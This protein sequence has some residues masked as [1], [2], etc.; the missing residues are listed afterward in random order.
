MANF[1]SITHGLNEA[2]AYLNS[3]YSWIKGHT[4]KI[5]IVSP[6]SSYGVFIYKWDTQNSRWITEFNGNC[7]DDGTNH[8]YDDKLDIDLSL[9]YD[10]ET[11]TYS[12]TDYENS[13]GLPS[14]DSRTDGEK[15]WDDVKT[16][17]QGDDDDVKSLLAVLGAVGLLGFSGAVSGTAILGAA[18]LGLTIGSVYTYFK[19]NESVLDYHN[20][21]GN[22]F[23]FDMS[24]LDLDAGNFFD[25]VKAMTGFVPYDPLLKSAHILGNLADTLISKYSVS[26]DDQDN[27]KQDLNQVMAP[28]VDGA[29]EFMP[30]NQG[31]KGSY[32]NLDT[33]KT[34]LQNNL[35]SLSPAYTGSVGALTPEIDALPALPDFINDYFGIV[36]PSAIPGDLLQ[37]PSYPDGKVY[38]GELGGVAYNPTTGE[39]TVIKKG[40]VKNLEINIDVSGIISALNPLSYLIHLLAMKDTM[41]FNK[42]T[43]VE[44]RDILNAK[45]MSPDMTEVNRLVIIKLLADYGYSVDG[46]GALVKTGDGVRDVEKSVA[47]LKDAEY[48]HQ[49]DGKEKIQRDG[50]AWSNV[51][52]LADAG[53]LP[54]TIGNDV[55]VMKGLIPSLLGVGSLEL[56]RELF[57]YKANTNAA[58]KAKGKARE[59]E[60]ED[61]EESFVDDFMSMIFRFKDIDTSALP[62]ELKEHLGSIVSNFGFEQVGDQSGTE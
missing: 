61:K 27:F 29:L 13:P 34:L 32:L 9:D 12:Y 38:L 40:G 2:I 24:N 15:L 28:A 6:V 33:F 31:I 23:K 48:K 18:A 54:D 4:F 45:E 5:R 21:A 44:T 62:T 10:S 37:H 58:I 59:E 22:G 26:A 20:M 41:V 3:G 46:N 30:D 50:E 53:T 51:H 56:L 52:S 47:V 43:M 25:Q 39:A 1:T 55:P 19:N 11:E 16:D 8:L 36:P 14:K 60:D 42:T 57:I 49:V 35:A 7:A 17:L